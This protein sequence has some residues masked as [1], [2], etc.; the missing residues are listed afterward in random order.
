[1]KISANCF[2]SIVIVIFWITGCSIQK[3]G[4]VNEAQKAPEYFEYQADEVNPENT[5]FPGGRGADE[6][7]IYNP[8]FGEK[9]GTN[10]WGAE[11][12]VSAGLVEKV[13]GNNSS[14]P[15]NGF[16]ISGHGKASR[17]ILDHLKPGMKIEI[18][19]KTIRVWETY[20]SILYFGGHLIEISTDRLDNME[21]V[22]DSISMETLKEYR[23]A[24]QEN[25]KEA[26]NA[27]KNGD[28]PAARHH[29][30]KALDAAWNYFYKARP[31]RKNE[32]RACW[33]RLIARSP[34]ELEQTFKNLAEHGFNTLCPE[35]IYWG[36][37]IYPD[38]HPD[39]EQHP[40]FRGWDPLAEMIRLGK[41]Y[42]I[43]IIPWVEVYFIGFEDS[44]LVTRKAEWLAVSRSGKKA[45]SLEPGYYF[46]CPSRDDVM[47]FWMEVY[48]N[49][50]Q[51]YDID[52]LQMDYIRFPRSIPWEEGYCYCP[53]CREKFFNRYDIDPA[54]MTPESHPNFWEKWNE[55][56]NQQ[57][58][59]F[60]QETHRL[61]NRIKPGIRLSADVFP[62]LDEAKGAK[63]QDWPLW[64]ELGYLDEIYFMSY[65]P[66]L[67]Q[68]EN[69]IRKVN[70]MVPPDVH[71]IMGL[72]PY[73]GFDAE[74]LLEEITLA[75]DAGSDGVC[76]FAL[77]HLTPRH[78]EAI[79]KG[80]FRLKARVPSEK[81]FL[82]QEFDK[83]NPGDE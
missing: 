75:G 78:L 42:N 73:L 27:D 81:S 77:E 9:T 3:T 66:D 29:A 70:E 71:A 19:K 34:E 74:I 11:A 1:M 58:N 44:P 6:M 24:Y 53:V 31:S 38:A 20:Q 65:T 28:I 62:G 48:E 4:T 5:E 35:T 43:K 60:V 17:W 8:D 30:G 18:K 68:L 67:E 54:S 26:N 55:Y 22:P 46:F 57:V 82:I 76:L 59:A 69:E 21:S 80:P 63:F 2:A 56:R 40:D 64:L 33:H 79:S 49:L 14:I 12:V 41:K 52:G 51:N 7:I 23:E 32:I 50:L 83:F 61:V 13:G 45:S 10:E 15:A 36:Y 37:S 16:V 39:L 47:Q 25:V 72:G